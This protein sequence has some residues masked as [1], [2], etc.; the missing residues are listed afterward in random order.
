MSYWWCDNPNWQI[1]KSLHSE[2]VTYSG[3][4]QVP[5][6]RTFFFFLKDKNAQAVIVNSVRYEKMLKTF[7]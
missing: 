6:Q 2:W 7:L 4:F 5:H 1:T 3:P